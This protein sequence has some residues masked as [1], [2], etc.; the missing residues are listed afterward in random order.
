MPIY[1]YECKKCG[2]VFDFLQTRSSDTP[3]CERCNSED[4]EKKVTGF[5]VRM[6]DTRTTGHGCSGTCSC[7]R[8]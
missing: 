5:S 2:Q 6:E 3:V 7:S 8:N 4:L 1:R